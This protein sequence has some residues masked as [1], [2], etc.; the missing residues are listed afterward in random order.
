MSLAMGEHGQ[1]SPAEEGD[2]R[3]GMAW[4][5]N[6]R[7]RRSLGRKA[8]AIGGSLEERRCRAVSCPILPYGVSVG[9]GAGVDVVLAR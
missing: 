1:E 6:R 9:V 7:E 4:A 8:A 3:W 5:S 2:V